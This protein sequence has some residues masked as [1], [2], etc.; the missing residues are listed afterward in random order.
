MADTRSAILETA[1]RL[2]REQGFTATGVATILREAGV[3][4]GSLYHFFPSKEA[5]LLAVLERYTQLLYPVVL[6]P[7]EA[8]TPDPIDRVFTLLRQYRDWLAPGGFAQGCPIGNLALEMSDQLPQVRELV[9]RN[10]RGWY[11]G[12]RAW[13]DAAAPRLPVSTDRD[14]LAKLIL[15]VMEGGIMQARAANSPEPYDASVAELRRYFDLLLA[16]AAREK[17]LSPVSAPEE[18]SRATA[19][20]DAP[21]ARTTNGADSR[22]S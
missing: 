19:A 22:R 6:S 16:Q 17:T 5:L 18:I 15:T 3:N 11:Q 14:A 2:F 1:A 20:P 12:V 10:F 13:L 7:V 9:D 8:R 21:P 4:S